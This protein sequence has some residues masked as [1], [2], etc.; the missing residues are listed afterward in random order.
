[1][2]VGGPSSPGRVSCSAADWRAAALGVRGVVHCRKP[3]R[4]RQGG[5]EIA[6]GGTTETTEKFGRRDRESRAAE[7][8][9]DGAYVAR[10]APGFKLGAVIT[11]NKKS[12]DGHAQDRD[13][14]RN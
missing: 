8:P 13:P 2:T 3:L 14:S 1:M 11:N 4:R 7:K 6:A 10:I 5:A 12:D 9:A